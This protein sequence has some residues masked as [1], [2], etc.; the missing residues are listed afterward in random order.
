ML[1]ADYS[2]RVYA[3][4]VGKIIGVYLGRPFEGWTNERIEEQL[5]EIDF[6]VHDKVGVPLIVTDD[7]ISGTFTFIRA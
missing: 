1:P 6:Y 3:G 2:E 4:V 5:G 7:D